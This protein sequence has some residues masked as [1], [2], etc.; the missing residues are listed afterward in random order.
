MDVANGSI[1]CSLLYRRLV[2]QVGVS[3]CCIAGK[4]QTCT[5]VC[6]L[7]N[8][9]ATQGDEGGQGQPDSTAAAAKQGSAK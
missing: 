8:I 2:A 6:Q 9:A 3:A 1:R 4:S 7:L 5:A